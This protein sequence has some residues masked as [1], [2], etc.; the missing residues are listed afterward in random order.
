MK[1]TISILLSI[2][3]LIFS[4]FVFTSCFDYANT[5]ENSG[6]TSNRQNYTEIKLTLNNYEDYLSYNLYVDDVAFT[7]NFSNHFT[8]YYISYVRVIDFLPSK[9]GLVFDNVSITTSYGDISL[10]Y[11]GY[12]KTQ[13]SS[14][15]INKSMNIPKSDITIESIT[16]TVR[17]YE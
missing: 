4:S 10:D 15:T 17:V 2:V 14:S 1:K 3:L 12:G 6:E 16:G 7:A 5:M 11:N 9:S 13:Y 8:Q